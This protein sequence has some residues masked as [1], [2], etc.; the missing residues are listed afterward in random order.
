MKN[1]ILT[2]G[3]SVI[4]VSGLTQTLNG[5][6][7]S[8]LSAKYIQIVG[9]SKILKPMEVT[10]YVDYGQ[11]SK[12]SEFANGEVL[13]ATGKVMSFNGMLAV[14]NFFA[15]YGYVLEMAYPLSTGNGSV[16]HYI[17]RKES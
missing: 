4:A 1:L 2:L 13:D 9:T 8:E 14:V 6:P 16:Y 17:M 5:Q 15:E 7:L 10:I 12:F 3:L 11:I